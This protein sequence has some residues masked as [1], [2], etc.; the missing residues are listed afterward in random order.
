MLMLWADSTNP[1]THTPTPTPTPAHLSHIWHRVIQPL[2]FRLMTGDDSF[3]ESVGIAEV[4]IE[5]CVC[6]AEAWNSPTKEP[7]DPT[8]ISMS[9]SECFSR[10]EG[11]FNPVPVILAVS[12]WVDYIQVGRE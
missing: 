5:V 12:R 7:D 8:F 10:C 6:K 2:E 9:A 4:D 1:S 11:T 3:Y